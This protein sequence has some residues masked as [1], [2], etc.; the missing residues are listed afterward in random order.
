M[1]QRRRGE[2]QAR[3]TYRQGGDGRRQEEGLEVNAYHGLTGGGGKVV[4]LR[5]KSEFRL[6]Y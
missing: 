1:S 5:M 6:N 4:M 3:S 2:S